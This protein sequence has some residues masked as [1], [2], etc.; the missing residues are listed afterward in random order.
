MLR[1]LLVGL[2]GTAFSEAA[3][4]LAIRWAAS[5]GAMAAGIAV[6][7][8]PAICGSEPVPVGGAEF[9]RERD[10]ARLAD[11]RRQVGNFLGRFTSRCAAAGVA[12][13]VLENT[14]TPWEVINREGQRFDLVLLGRETHF[15]FETDR[16]PCETLSKV[17]RHGPRPL[18]V[19]PNPPGH[20]TGGILL[21]YDGSRES[22]RAA[23]ALVHLRPPVDGP[24]HVLSVAPE[25]LDA[26][27]LADRARDYLESHGLSV[28]PLP[29]ESSDAPAEVILAEA[30][31]LDAA[32]VV[33]GAC[34]KSVFREFF[35]GSVT[36]TL[37]AKAGIPLLLTH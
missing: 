28:R 6:L 36:R 18:V 31:R 26:A 9:K 12:A 13:K 15:H 10:A 1:R 2:D 17:L 29:V 32:L 3:S 25:H 34:G 37:L 30:G 16:G 23:E 22:A 27:K 14:G 24:V 11:A 35:L 19:V 4:E 21:A 5:A 8:E 20:G 33:A 7:D